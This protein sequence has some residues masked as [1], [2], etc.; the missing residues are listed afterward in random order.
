MKEEKNIMIEENREIKDLLLYRLLDCQSE[1]DHEKIFTV[2]EKIRI[3]FGDKVYY[4]GID[5]MASFMREFARSSYD[6]FLIYLYQAAL[7]IATKEL[8]GPENHFTS[9]DDHLTRSKHITFHWEY[10]FEASDFDL[11]KLD[12]QK[13]AKTVKMFNEFLHKS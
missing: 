1:E 5:E 3:I 8:I 6:C 9:W 10:K 11:F 4:K 12:P 7:N 2:F 13:V